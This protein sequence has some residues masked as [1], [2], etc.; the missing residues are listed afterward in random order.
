MQALG[1]SCGSRA[2]ADLHV[3][4]L[5]LFSQ[6]GFAV[7]L[8]RQEAFFIGEFRFCPWPGRLARIETWASA[9]GV[10]RHVLACERV[11]GVKSYPTFGFGAADRPS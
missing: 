2:A 9:R 4:I 1:K 6:S 7:D 5:V 3:G 8:D 11:V 10:R